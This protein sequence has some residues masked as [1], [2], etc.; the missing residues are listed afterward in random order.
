MKK[1]IINVLLVLLCLNVCAQNKIATLPNGQKVVLYPD[2]TWDYYK[3][4]KY[5]FDFS[6]IKD[7]E[8]PSFLRKGIT[9]KKYILKEAVIMYFQGWRYTM[10]QPKSNQACWGNYDGRTTWWYGY[11]YN[12]KTK[13]YSSSD[14]KKQLNGDYKGDMQNMKGYYRRGGSPARPNKIQWLLSSGGGC[15]I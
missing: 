2:M 5:N 13:K 14:L 11:W 1:I 8:I 4:N 12:V 6:K 7:N 3:E 15:R 9:V 10:P